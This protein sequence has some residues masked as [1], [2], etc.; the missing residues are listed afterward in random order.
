MPEVKSKSCVPI[1][2]KKA[3]IAFSGAPQSPGIIYTTNVKTIIAMNVRGTDIN[4][5]GLS[6]E[7]LIL[8]IRY[9]PNK[10]K[11]TIHKAKY[12]SRSNRFQL[13]AKSTLDKNFNA[14]ASSR[15]P[16]TTFTLFSQPPDFGRDFS[17]DGNI[18]KITK[19]T[20]NA[21]EKP[22]IPIA[23]PNRSPF[24][25]ASTSK[26]P[27]IG[28]VH[29]KETT[30]KL[31]DMKNKPI[32]P[33]LSDCAS[34]LLT[35]ELGKV[36]SNA[37]KNEA[38]NTTKSKK[39]KKL[40][41]PLVDKA[42]NASG[43][44]ATVISIPNATYIT[45]IKRPYKKAWLT[46]LLLEPDF[47]VKKLTVKGTIGKI[48]GMKKAAKP[49]N[50]PAINIPHKDCFSSAADVVNTSDLICV[51]STFAFIA[52]LSTSSEK[53][54][55]SGTSTNPEVSTLSDSVNSTSSNDINESCVLAK[56]ENEISK[57]K[58]NEKNRDF[59]FNRYF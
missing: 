39:K 3:D 54:K 34:I 48:Q 12:T 29:E 50:K 28:P 55:S 52:E 58:K 18:A 4:C 16:K 11:I 41:I 43:P 45:T 59:I 35:K 53:T 6:C 22:N 24:V 23:G 27:I 14:K 32:Q 37:P 2:G 13:Y 8:P 46:A 1:G 21:K 15:N 51:L 31:A 26:V 56:D 19:G 30:D 7:N 44:K 9:K 57:V 38:A 47:L 40:K 20:A 42:F 10:A 36:I 17:M 25:A 5:N 49:P 33:L